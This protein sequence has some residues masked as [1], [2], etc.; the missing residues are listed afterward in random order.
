MRSLQYKYDRTAEE[1]LD[2]IQDKKYA[3]K[4]THSGYTIY[5]VGI[6]INRK[7]IA[8]VKMKLIR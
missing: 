3:D 7:A 6:S 5:A 8:D 2:Q 1:A 4:F